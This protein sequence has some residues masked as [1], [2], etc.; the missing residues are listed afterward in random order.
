[1][2]T[3]DCHENI[4]AAVQDI[5]RYYLNG[6]KEVSE[7]IFINCQPSTFIS[8]QSSDVNNDLYTSD[9]VK[10]N[11]DVLLQVIQ[12]P[13]DECSSMLEKHYKIPVVPKSVSDLTKLTSVPIPKKRQEPTTKEEKTIGLTL[14]QSQ[15]LRSFIPMKNLDERRQYLILLD[16]TSIFSKILT[17]YGKHLDCE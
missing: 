6:K 9:Y 12:L 7:D 3:T 2:T 13:E 4:D 14:S 1:M 16:C 8:R 10:N 5:P 11:E 17:Y 15:D